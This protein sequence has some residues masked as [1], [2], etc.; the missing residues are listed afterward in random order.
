M[1]NRKKL[2]K[3]IIMY[4]NEILNWVSSFTTNKKKLPKKIVTMTCRIIALSSMA[5]HFLE[6][7]NFC[8]CYCCLKQHF[9]FLTILSQNL[10]LDFSIWLQVVF[11]IQRENLKKIHSKY[12]VTEYVLDFSKP[13]I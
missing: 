9:K 10:D 3:D 8:C 4:L 1:W 7:F 11:N 5:N 2:F 12:G 6:I 13:I